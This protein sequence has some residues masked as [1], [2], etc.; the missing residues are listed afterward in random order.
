MK[1]ESEEGFILLYSILAGSFL[2]FLT[3]LFILS[4]KVFEGQKTEDVK[5]G[6]KIILR[7]ISIVMCLYIFIL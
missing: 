1:G 4:G 2:L 5:E 3:V 7:G 6:T